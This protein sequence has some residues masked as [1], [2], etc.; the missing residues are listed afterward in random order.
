LAANTAL[1]IDHDKATTMSA[2]IDGGQPWR[3]GFGDN[4]TYTDWRRDNFY[5]AVR[6]LTAGARRI[7]IELGS[8]QEQCEIVR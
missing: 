3:R 2:G 5:R 1:V 7:G 8:E 4:I 6:Q